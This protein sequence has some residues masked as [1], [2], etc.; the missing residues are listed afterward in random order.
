M[1]LSEGELGVEVKIRLGGGLKW[2]RSLLPVVVVEGP[3][4]RPGTSQK[5]SAHSESFPPSTCC[6]SV[7]TWP[8][9]SGSTNWF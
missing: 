4:W 7:E 1:A 9:L 5:N 2:L 8:P 3:G 6:T